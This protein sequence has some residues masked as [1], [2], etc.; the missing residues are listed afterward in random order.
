M[1]KIETHG[2]V[3]ILL[4]YSKK[5]FMMYMVILLNAPFTPSITP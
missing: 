4:I 3:A 1:F 5:L 2:D